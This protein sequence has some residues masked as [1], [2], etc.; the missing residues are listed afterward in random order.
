MSQIQLGEKEMLEE[1]IKGLQPPI[2]GELVGEI[3]EKMKLAAEAGFLLKIDE[4]IR[5]MVQKAKI[6]VFEDYRRQRILGFSDF[7][8]DTF[9]GAAE[10]RLIDSLRIY[11]EKNAH[12]GHYARRL[13]A[14]NAARGFAFVELMSKNYDIVLMNPP[15]G[16]CSKHSK[17]YRGGISEDKK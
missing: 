17:A 5:D 7:K 14:E 8:D 13:F 3:W 6:E 2:L 15:F 10:E 11:A 9:W 4:E 1:F 12:D 16:E